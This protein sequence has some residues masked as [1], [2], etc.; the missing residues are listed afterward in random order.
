MI[1]ALHDM[2]EAR[3]IDRGIMLTAILR[4]KGK[5]NAMQ[6]LQAVSDL[7][8]R[9]LA[10]MQAEDPDADDGRWV[11]LDVRRVAQRLKK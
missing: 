9:L 7:E 8:E 1:H 6:V 2:A 4:P 11:E 10:L 3:L 5:G